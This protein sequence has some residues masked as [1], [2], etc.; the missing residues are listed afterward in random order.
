MI[1]SETRDIVVNKYIQNHRLERRLNTD[2]APTEDT[3][4]AQSGYLIARDKYELQ[5]TDE[6]LEAV[7]RGEAIRVAGG[8]AGEI[9][10]L[11]AEA[12]KQSLQD[13]REK[14][15]LAQLTR[16]AVDKW[17]RDNPFDS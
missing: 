12:Y 5:L 6:Q 2:G 3:V 7:R 1:D 10:V 13:E 11:S 8:D 4:N 15:E 17:G 16:K 9:V 14:A